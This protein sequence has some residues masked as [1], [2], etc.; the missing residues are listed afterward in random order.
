VGGSDGTR[1]GSLDLPSLQKT[2]CSVFV[3]IVPSATTY[4]PATNKG[5]PLCDNLIVPRIANTD[6]SHTISSC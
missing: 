1:L 6:G 2:A 3:S 4:R 5:M